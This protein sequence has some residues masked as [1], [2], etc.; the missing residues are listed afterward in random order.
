MRTADL[1]L[2]FVAGLNGSGPDHWQTRW[3]SRLPTARLVEQADWDRPKLSHW[4]RAIVEACEAARRPIVLV[5][6]SLGVTTVAHAA[7]LLPEGAV[8]GA[9]LVAPPSD[10]TLVAVG[11][12]E[13]APTPSAPLPFASLLIASR[14]DPHGAYSFA[15]TKASQWG[16]RLVAAGEAGHINAD[17]GHGPWPEG[18]VQFAAFIKG[19]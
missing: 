1:D 10:E 11:A 5:A 8:K 18:L 15:E 3:R 12:G 19:L 17:S 6:H 9:F 14:N 13:F 7:P 4:V 2:L 16:S